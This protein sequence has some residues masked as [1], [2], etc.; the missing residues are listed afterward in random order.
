MMN[1]VMSTFLMKHVKI[2]YPIYLTVNQ[3]INPKQKRSELKKK[4]H[5]NNQRGIVH[6]QHIQKDSQHSK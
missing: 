4:I 2:F 1:F 3:T 5:H 6:V